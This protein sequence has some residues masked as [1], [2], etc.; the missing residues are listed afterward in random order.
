MDPS[1][2]D[3]LTAFFLDLLLFLLLMGVFFIYRRLRS[4]EIK[5]EI[6][7][8]INKP[9]MHEGEHSSKDL[10]REVL[11]MN[12]DTIHAEVGE[13]GFVYLAFLK[14]SI[15][16][17]I[18]L[19]ALGLILIIVYLCGNSDTDRDFDNAGIAHIM[20][21][22]NWLLAPFFF[23]LTF[24][25]VIYAFGHY[26][27]QRINSSRAHE[28]VHTAKHYTVQIKG[29]PINYPAHVINDY[30]TKILK[31][32]YGDGIKS[33]YVVP[34]LTE[35]YEN[36][37]ELKNYQKQLRYLKYDYEK[38][39]IRPLIREKLW[40]KV[41]G[42]SF[43]QE[44]I[45]KCNLN[46]EEKRKERYGENAGVCFVICTTRSLAKEIIETGL[47]NQ[48]GPYDVQKWVFKQ[49]TTPGDL[50]WESIGVQ[51]TA[52]ILRK[53]LINAIFIL[54][55]LIFMTPGS[56]VSAIEVICDDIGITKVIG[57]VLAYYLPSLLMLLYQILILPA[58][59]EFMVK[60]E[61]HW[62][63]HSEVAS[64]LKKYLFFLFFYTFLYPMLGLQFTSLIRTLV[65]DEDKWK[66]LFALS[67][68][69]L[70]EFYTIFI[71]H[72][73]FLKNG[74]DLLVASKYIVSTTKA[75]FATTSIEKQLAYESDPFKFD[76]ELAI[77]LNTFII[78]CSFSVIYPF[79]LIPGIMFFTIRVFYI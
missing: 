7:V 55:F 50:V 28:V 12:L 5:V 10:I 6:E 13:W 39:K 30:I 49:A 15:F 75:F 69:K 74:W 72:Q 63:K 4:P 17:F 70:A 40:K 45:D 9:Y 57:S 41:D 36:F 71:I 3:I 29:F 37:V 66:N 43:Y 67:A 34:Q 68:V 65:E 79:I 26:M 1:I 14:Y 42:I 22:D 44:K 48:S 77:S 35:A 64:G 62:M 20:H 73:A 60:Q 25:I 11:N 61:K 18:I 38:T 16:L 47:K 2:V 56:F 58:A 59:V 51:K 52:S 23:F 33:V 78:I 53:V 32:Q 8:S 46:V 31:E 21:M 76:L 54:V 19:F 24:S 27:L